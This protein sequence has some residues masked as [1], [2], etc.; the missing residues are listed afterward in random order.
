MRYRRAAILCSILCSVGIPAAD[1]ALPPYVYEQA[2]DQA[3]YHLQIKVMGVTPPAKT[4]GECETSG[5]V[6]RIFRDRSRTLRLGTRLAFAVS[7]SRRGDPP[8]V[9]GVLWTDYDA[10]MRAR[11]L[12]AFLNHENGRY[13]VALSQSRIIEAPTDKP[14]IGPASA[15][16]PADRGSRPAVAGDPYEEG[17]RLYNAKQD[18]ASLAYFDRAIAANPG[19]AEAYAGRGMA[20][21]ALGEYPRAIEGCRCFPAGRTSPCSMGRPRRTA[22]WR[23]RWPPRAHPRASGRSRARA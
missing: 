11:Y 18:R 13:Q 9:G 15:A 4:P 12:E 16:P 3:T 20:Y 7:C 23:S 1:A 14:V 5:E 2:R 6:V 21:H 8:I 19:R 10:L 22:S 17:M